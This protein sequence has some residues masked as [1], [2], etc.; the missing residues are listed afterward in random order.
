[1]EMSYLTPCLV[2]KHDIKS[3]NHSVSICILILLLKLKG[4]GGKHETTIYF[5][6]YILLFLLLDNNSQ[7]MAPINKF[8]S[9]GFFF[10]KN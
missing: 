2:H 6:K 5:V 8:Y 7:V 10:A 9:S 3:H 4:H 1:M